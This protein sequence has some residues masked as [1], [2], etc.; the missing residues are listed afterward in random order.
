M[1]FAIIIQA[2]TGSRR[3]PKKILAR[4]DRRN[5]LEFFI[6]RLLQTFSKNKIIIATTKFKR[7]NIV[8]NISKKKKIKFYRGP[9]KNV[10]KRFLNCAIKFNVKN[11]ARVTPDCPLV[12][13][14]LLQSM[15]KQFFI[16]KLD[17]LANTNPPKKSKFPDGS[18]IEIFKFR[19]LQKI[20]RLS[21]NKDDREHVTHLFWKNPKKFKIKIINK[22]KNISNYKFSIDYKH[23]L[24]LVKKV[25]N[26][27]KISKK[28]GNA[29]EIVNII[30][31]DK[32]L[33]KI[34]EM[35]RRKFIKNRNDLTNF[36]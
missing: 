6:D 16:R 24:L 23:D 26:K 33:N 29:D 2:R 1:N 21:K 17:Y 19:S 12:D 31:H 10:L 11:I 14:R 35:S 25:I 9:E 4:I 18:D 5:V 15:K 13:P 7:D 3:F 8:C 28:Y 20:Y 34:S 32:K 30:K 27:I 22:K 36:I